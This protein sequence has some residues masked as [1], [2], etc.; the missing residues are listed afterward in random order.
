MYDSEF[1]CTY[2]M[3]DTEEEQEHLYKIQFLQ[4][5]GLEEWD[6]EL[7]HEYMTDLYNL[8]KTDVNLQQILLNLSQVE[9][10]RDFINSTCK[11]VEQNIIDSNTLVDKNMILF[12]FLFQ[13]N[14]FD[15]FHKCIYDF[16]HTLGIS[17]TRM[18]TLVKI[19]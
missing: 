5:F 7:I 1:L 17:D 11:Y 16:Q 10:V 9:T 4:A 2:K 12:T 14:Y 6:D 13:Y 19:F 15:V 3:M 18:Q 8:M